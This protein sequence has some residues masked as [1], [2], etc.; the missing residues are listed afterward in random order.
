MNISINID[1]WR[2]WSPFGFTVT[3]VA[4]DTNEFEPEVVMSRRVLSKRKALRL[5]NMYGITLSFVYGNE[6]SE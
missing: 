4:W 5:A 1:Q 6:E 3:G 2:S